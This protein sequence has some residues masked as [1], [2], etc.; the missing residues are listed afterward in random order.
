TVSVYSLRARDEPTASTPVR[1]EELDA[2]LKAKD[3]AALR[4]EAPE[5]VKRVEADGD[6]FAAVHEVTQELPTL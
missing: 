1:W 6:L 3:A 5:V 4:F 2:A